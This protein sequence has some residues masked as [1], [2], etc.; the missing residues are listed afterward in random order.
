MSQNFVDCSREQVFLLPPDVREWLPADHL[1]W[2]VL[3]AVAEMDLDG[4]YAA[5]RADGHGRP[6]YDPAMMIALLLYA[7]SRNERSSRVIERECLED[8]A[9]RVIAANERPDHSTIARFVARHEEA[10]AGVFGSVLRVCAKA[11]L[12]KT[13]VIAVDGSKVPA[14]VN[15]ER[16]LD[17]E[18]I[19]REILKE[20]QAV[21]AAEDELYGEKRGDELPPELATS[22]GRKAW[23]REAMREL[24]A[25]QADELAAEDQSD[26]A[27]ASAEFEFD[28][29]QVVA[30]DQGRKGWPREAKRQLDQHRAQNPRPVPRS[31]KERLLAALRQL[32]EELD[33]ERQ[34]NEA[35][36]AYRAQGRMK[37]GRRF[38]C[39][40]KPYVPPAVPPGVIN[41]TDPDSRLLKATKGYVQG[42]NAQFVTTENQIVI[43][44][45]ITV[46][47]GDFNHLEPM[48]A[49][50]RTELTN[51]GI[52]DNSGVTVADAGYWN[53][54]QMDNLAADGITVLIPPDSPKRRGARPGWQGGR[55][56]WMRYLLATDLGGGLYR[57]RQAMIE[58]VFAQTKHNRGM[59]RFRRRG[60]S[61][62]RT[63]WRLIAA[64]HN[65]MK[66]HKHQLAVAAT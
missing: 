44:A 61:A 43:A 38:G 51:A 24:E 21:D 57:K 30:R 49:A 6:A 3:D 58:P 50:A 39:P 54:E 14:A 55:Y 23:L 28:A 36:Q 59:N 12:V 63:E 15:D 8:I 42:Y 25:E 10:L 65:L 16:M 1:V 5:Y 64:T 46:A 52:T 22:E 62:V 13:G 4:F 40:P 56:T 48:V 7:Y 18:Q 9:Y 29:A 47:P 60:R 17:Y 26:D 11:G 19:A 37:D 33:A 20:A 45:E 31:R 66:L 53:R 27:V 35:Y 32:E 41:V 2:L 34:A